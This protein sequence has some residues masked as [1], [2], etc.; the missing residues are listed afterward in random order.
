MDAYSVTLNSLIPAKNSLFLEIFS[1]L[2]CVGNWAKSDCSA[3]VSCYKI[4]LESPE[5]AKLP[6]K[7]PDNREFAWRPVRSALRRQPGTRPNPMFNGR[8]Q[9]SCGGTS[10]MT[11]ECQ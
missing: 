9:P 5:I 7:F 3:A 2:I 6:V 10:R 8:R 4:G 11:R 1:L